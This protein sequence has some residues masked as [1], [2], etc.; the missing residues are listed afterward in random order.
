MN[1]YMSLYLVFLFVVLTPGILLRIPPKS[2]KLVVAVVHGLVFALVYCLTYKFVLNATYVENFQ[3]VKDPKN[4]TLYERYAKETYAAYE[5]QKDPIIKKQIFAKFEQYRN[6][7]NDYCMPIVK[8]PAPTVQQN[9]PSII[10]QIMPS[11]KKPAGPPAHCQKYVRDLNNLYTMKD[12]AN[13]KYEN[14]MATMKRD[15]CD[16]SASGP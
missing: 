3:D 8:K 16:P 10:Q 12:N 1:L 11:I 9:K 6:M 13:K 2:S 14:H 5:T 15:G 4:C 7:M